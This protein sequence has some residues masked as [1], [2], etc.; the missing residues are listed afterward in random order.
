MTFSFYDHVDGNSPLHRIDA[1]IKV[2]CAFTVIFG[3][4]FLMHWEIPLI[5][6][7]ICVALVFYSHSKPQIYFKRLLYPIYIIIFVALTQPFTNVII[8]GKPSIIVAVLPV[9]NW[10]IY[11]AGI[12][13]A[14]L[15]F[16]RCLAAIAV[17]NLLILLTPMERILDSLRWFKIPS[18]IV[19]TMMLMFRYISLISD[20][21]ARIRKAQESRL[22]YSK[23]VGVRKK[24]G[25]FGILAG[26]LM[27]RS[28]DRAIQVG[29]AMISRGYTGASSLFTYTVEKVPRKD[30]LIGVF[31]ILATLS[32]VITDLF[33]I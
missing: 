17:L 2:I 27:A 24:I 18:V 28:F 30:I 26:M 23:K 14:L 12:N 13:F 6:F 25:N 32:L 33:I 3:V 10:P 21:S 31:V 15:I 1:R 29:D 8:G 9:L 5:V 11:Q 16:A 19:D 22:G 7:G 4:V 20:E